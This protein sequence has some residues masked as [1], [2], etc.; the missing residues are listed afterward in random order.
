M[1]GPPGLSHA[2]RFVAV[3]EYEVAIQVDGRARPD[4]RDQQD[5]RRRASQL[6]REQPGYG[7]GDAGD[8]HG[9]TAEPMREPPVLVAVERPWRLA[10]KRVVALDLGQVVAKQDEAEA[11]ARA[12]DDS[13]GLPSCGMMPNTTSSVVHVIPIMKSVKTATNPV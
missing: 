11:Q 9:H 4:D 3:S 2:Q 7:D 5:C 13:D 12:D 10:A 1:A 8:D 6:L